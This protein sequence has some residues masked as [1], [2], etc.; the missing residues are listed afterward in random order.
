MISFANLANSEL[1]IKID[2][3]TVSSIPIIIDMVGDTE[4]F[5]SSAIKNI[6]KSR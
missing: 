6:I 3:S 5:S 4:D 2:K 1:V